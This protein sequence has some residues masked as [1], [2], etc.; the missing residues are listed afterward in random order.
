[1]LNLSRLAESKLFKGLT[2]E[3][4]FDELR[5]ISFLQKTFREGETIIQEGE[6]LLFIGLIVEGS[7]NIV[8]ISPSGKQYKIT[9]LKQGDTIGEAIVFSANSQAPASVVAEEKT[10]ILFFDKN[11][12][13]KLIR[14]N[15]R[16]LRNYLRILSDRILMMAKRL[17]ESTLMTLRQKICNYILEEYKRKRSL[18]IQLS[19]TKEQLAE[20]FA[21]ER[22]SLSR[23]LIKMR[24]EGI[25]D[26]AGKTIRIID[27]EK[28][29]DIVYSK[30]AYQ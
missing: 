7:V 29:E 26:F 23:E 21:V 25:I 11:A 8:H 13:M 12:I 28:I 14:S 9:T 16:I 17:K 15:E 5:R 24:D 1:M 19:S 18:T 2:E 27:L 10:C 30:M 3:E 6:E 20:L 22:P 4:L